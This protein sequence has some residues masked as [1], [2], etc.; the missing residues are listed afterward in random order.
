[1]FRSRRPSSSLHAP[2]SSLQAQGSRRGSA[3]PNPFPR[4]PAQPRLPRRRNPPLPRISDLIFETGLAARSIADYLR[5]GGLRMG[6]TG[7][8]RSGKTVFVTA[9]VQDL[10]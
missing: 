7:L 2:S 9:L 8:S 3:K 4:A 1:M 5:G 6:V 10:L